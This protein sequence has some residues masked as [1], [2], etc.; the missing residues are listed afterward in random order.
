MLHTYFS[1]TLPLIGFFVYIICVLVLVLWRQYCKY[2]NYYFTNTEISL[3]GGAFNHVFSVTV[4]NF[5]IFMHLVK[6]WVFLFVLY[7]FFFLKINSYNYKFI[8]FNNFIFNQLFLFTL[9]FLIAVYFLFFKYIR[10]RSYPVDVGIF[11]IFLYFSGFTLLISN[12]F[13][14][15]FIVL[16]IINLL[17]IYSFIIHLQF[18]NLNKH[19]ILNKS[20]WLL[21]SCI[22]QFIL[23]F[24][25]SILFYFSFN[26]LISTTSLTTFWNLNLFN[27]VNFNLTSYFT[28]VYVS[29]FIKFG[30]GPW[31]FFKIEIYKN[32][33][34]ILLIF[35]TITYFL[36]LLIF[37]FNL[38]FIYNLPINLL[39]FFL[40]LFIL[41]C[42]V[43]I[44]SVFLQTYFNLFIF[45]SFSS[46]LNLIA[47]FF[48]WFAILCIL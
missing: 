10:T 15:V 17:I 41:M 26:M 45:F 48:Q 19:L 11:L 40:L 35:Y 47:I 22:Y 34:F 42:L 4:S 39:Q 38:F 8:Y 23:N 25:S 32:F 36:I 24:F 7:F 44:F 37:F 30:I 1:F 31:I 33:N 18:N 16:E 43:F 46:L 27:S 2:T 28:L 20:L 12:N 29:F 9:F 13:L 5:Y 14:N 6:S 21:N 3:F